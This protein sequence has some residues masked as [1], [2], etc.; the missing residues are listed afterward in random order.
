MYQNI[1]LKNFNTYAKNGPYDR[2]N[3][4]E[5]QNILLIIPHPQNWQPNSC[6]LSLP[7]TLREDFER[8]WFKPRNEIDDCL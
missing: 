1:N 7:I 6:K 8:N 5:I 4:K 2:T 3:L